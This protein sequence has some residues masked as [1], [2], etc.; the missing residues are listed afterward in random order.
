MNI[1]ILKKV[2]EELN[3]ESPK[4]DY[5]RGMVETLIEMQEETKV[6][7]GLESK[8]NAAPTFSENGEHSGWKAPE[9]VQQDEGSLLDAQAKAA[10][11]KTMEL[12]NKSVE[13]D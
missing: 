8:G 11:E 6:P 12:A 10:I 3:K 9:V 13:H 1:N 2:S 7:T 5:I 4:L